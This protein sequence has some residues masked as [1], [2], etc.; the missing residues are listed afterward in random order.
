MTQQPLTRNGEANDLSHEDENVGVH[1]EQPGDRPV[2][3]TRRSKIPNAGEFAALDILLFASGIKVFIGSRAVKYVNHGLLA[4]A[5]ICY[6]V[7][8]I[9]GFEQVRTSSKFSILTVLEREIRALCGL[10]FIWVIKRN[11][12][13]IVSVIPEV[14]SSLTRDQRK[15]LCRHS[16][17]CVLLIVLTILQEFAST[18]WHLANVKS[19]PPTVKHTLVDY[20]KSYDY[21]NS[22]FLGGVAIYAF[23]VKAIM[24]LD[25]NFFLMVRERGLTEE[26]ASK[27]ALGRKHIMT[28]R[29]MMLGSLSVM[30]CLWFVHLFIKA[31]AATIEVVERFDKT[32][33]KIWR[34]AP[35]VYMILAILYLVWLCDLCTYRLRKKVHETIVSIMRKDQTEQMDVFV[36]ELKEN[37]AQEITSWDA[38]DVNRKFT[39]A[40]VSSLITFVVLFVQLTYDVIDSDN[41]NKPV[42]CD[43]GSGARVNGTRG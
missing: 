3:P 21:V 36:Q 1:V 18:S 32:S 25:D 14:L 11:A 10:A 30:P 39:I 41:K 6:T 43:C 37:G 16:L 13:T 33:D 9:E 23:Y 20:A 38:F 28:Q 34:L 8:F 7:S 31:S 15:S 29:E 26:S 40:F 12:S 22:W 42:I 19:W 35:L 17:A 24:F 4:I 5:L 2:T 27:L